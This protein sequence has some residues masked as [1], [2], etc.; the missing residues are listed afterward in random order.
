MNRTHLWLLALITPM[1]FLVSCAAWH[2]DET[3]IHILGGSDL[4]QKRMRYIYIGLYEYTLS[5][6]GKLPTSLL[7]LLSPE[8]E[9]EQ[10]DLYCPL[11]INGSSPMMMYQY[12]GEDLVLGD[13]K[14][15][16]IIL[17]APAENP[18]KTVNALFADGS[19]KAVRSVD[20][21]A[22]DPTARNTT[23]VVMPSN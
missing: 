14:R 18:D 15:D 5:H 9:Y 13:L 20:F 3:R 6:K 2:R 7:S 4:C 23:K 11:S 10:A 22:R 21:S 8:F 16:T 19:V 17:F 12:C 1:I